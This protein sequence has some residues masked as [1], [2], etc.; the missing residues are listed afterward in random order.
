[1]AWE[2]AERDDAHD[3][4]GPRLPDQVT[5]ERARLMRQVEAAGQRFSQ[6]VSRYN[7]AIGQFP[8]RLLAWLFA[9]KPARGL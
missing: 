9:F 8:A 5:S 7:E 1:L 4:A 6:A 2:R 3:L